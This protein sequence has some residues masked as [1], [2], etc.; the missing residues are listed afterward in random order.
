MSTKNWVTF[1]CFGTLVDWLT[2]FNAILAP[3]AGTRISQLLQ[4]YHENER[5]AEVERP[6]L[7]YRQVLVNSLLRAAEHTRIGISESQARRLPDS[8][9][10]LPV[11][12]DVEPMLA[13]LRA[14][15][16]SLGV[17]TNC[18]EDLFAQTQSCFQKPFDLVI[19]AERVGEYKPSLSHFHHFWRA[20]GA[21]RE[22]WV[23]VACSWFHDISPAR[24]F[25]VRSIWL[26]R[27]GGT[28]DAAAATARVKHAADVPPLVADLFGQRLT[29]SSSLA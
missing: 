8:W 24:E 5:L 10:K 6:H 16:C 15:G 20:S 9:R 23:H 13:R 18:D 3:L 22:Q 4:A 19:T 1:D 21:A 7:L 26:D 11:F 17:L 14:M 25:R 2:G 29:G 12:P 27:E 28:D